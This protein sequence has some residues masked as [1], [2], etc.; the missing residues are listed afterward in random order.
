M[1]AFFFS[2]E[3]IAFCAV[4]PFAL[5]LLGPIRAQLLDILARDPNGPLVGW[6]L[7]TR[8]KVARWLAWPIACFCATVVIAWGLHVLQA[9]ED[10]PYQN[11]DV[12]IISQD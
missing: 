5:L 3:F 8:V 10:A 11:Y 4:L 12:R 1:P 2:E 7:H 6:P 9:L